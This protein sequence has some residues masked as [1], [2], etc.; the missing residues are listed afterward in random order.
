LSLY[1]LSLTLRRAAVMTIAG[2]L[3]GAALAWMGTPALRGMLYGVGPHD[4]IA[5]GA[6]TTLLVATALGA[7]YLPARR[8]LRLDVVHALRES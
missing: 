3:A 2:V 1:V 7:A 6:A 8:L 5:L 4:P